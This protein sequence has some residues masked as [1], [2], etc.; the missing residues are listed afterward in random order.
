M[1]V[2][3]Y[4]EVGMFDCAPIDLRFLNLKKLSNTLTEESTGLLDLTKEFRQRLAD[5]KYELEQDAC[6][7]ASVE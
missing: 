5:S 2:L 4:A 7:H 1:L 6:F 3:F